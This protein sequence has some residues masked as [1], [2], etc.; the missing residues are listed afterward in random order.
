MCSR[1]ERRCFYVGKLRGMTSAPVIFSIF[2]EGQVEVS[3]GSFLGLRCGCFHG[4]G[5]VGRTVAKVSLSSS[6][7][8]HGCSLVRER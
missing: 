7:S 6:S 8:R 1:K 3:E 4:S 2:G 5:D